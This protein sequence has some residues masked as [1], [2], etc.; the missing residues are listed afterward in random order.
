MLAL[1]YFDFKDWLSQVI[2]WL[3]WLGWQGNGWRKWHISQGFDPLGH[4]VVIWSMRPVEMTY[5]VMEWF[6]V[7][8]SSYLWPIRPVELTHGVTEDFQSVNIL[9]YWPY[10]SYSWI[11]IKVVKMS[12]QLA[13]FILLMPTLVTS[14]YTT[15]L[16]LI[17]HRI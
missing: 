4:H 2:S 8:I 5:E 16:E 9:T 11:F 6:E 13:R 14:T 12:S 3:P 15:K 10:Y 7:W 17:L 1:C